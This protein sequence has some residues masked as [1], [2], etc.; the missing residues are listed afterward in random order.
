MFIIVLSLL[1]ETTHATE[2]SEQDPKKYGRVWQVEEGAC[3]IDTDEPECIMSPNFPNNYQNDE[4]CSIKLTGDRWWL[5]RTSSFQ[6]EEY[7]DTVYIGSCAFSGNLQGQLTNQLFRNQTLSWWSDGSTTLQG[8]RI[9]A[10][11]ADSSREKSFLGRT[12]GSAKWWAI[13]A[14]AI[15]CA[16]AVTC[17]TSKKLHSQM[18]MLPRDRPCREAAQEP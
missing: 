18:M 3:E 2:G 5:L 6:T 12:L 16:V 9:C 8:W 17:C 1:L 15:L 7:H 4:H 10:V 13:L 14:P 11:D